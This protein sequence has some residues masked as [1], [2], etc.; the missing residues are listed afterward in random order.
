MIFAK[1][2]LGDAPRGLGLSGDVVR[3]P[4][5][6]GLSTVVFAASVG[7]LSFAGFEAAG[8]FGEESKRPTHTIPRSMIGAIAF[9]GVFYVICIA[10]QT[11][12]FGTDAA[13]VKAFS[14]SVRPARRPR[15]H[16]TSARRWQTCSTSSRW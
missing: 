2:A 5:G 12:G 6:I 8:S 3:L 11:L 4:S 10:A 1:L 16:A 14:G 9:G 15:A 7:F 13:G